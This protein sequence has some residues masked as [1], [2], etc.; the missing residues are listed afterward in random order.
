MSLW[1]CALPAWVFTPDMSGRPIPRLGLWGLF[2]GP[3]TPLF[4]TIKEKIVLTVCHSGSSLT[5]CQV[6]DDK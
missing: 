2:V 1:V 6:P 4:K 5:S 3:V